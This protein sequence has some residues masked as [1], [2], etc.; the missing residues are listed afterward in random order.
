MNRVGFWQNGVLRRLFLA[1]RIVVRILSPDFSPHFCGKKCPEQ[2][3]SGKN[4]AKSSKIHTTESPTHFCRRAGPIITLQ[5]NSGWGTLFCFFVCAFSYF[6]DSGVFLGSVV[7]NPA[8][9]CG[10]RKRSVAC[11]RCNQRRLKDPKTKVEQLPD[12]PYPFNQGGGG[13]PP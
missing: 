7:S 9:P 6:W 12:N 2:K 3:P 1:R 13:S 5:P 10:D 8:K 11:M 4:P